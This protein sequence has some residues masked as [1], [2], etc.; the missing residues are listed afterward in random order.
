MDK[1]NRVLIL[2]YN[3]LDLLG[4]DH[5]ICADALALLDML[6]EGFV[7]LS[8]L[9]AWTGEIHQFEDLLHTPV[10]LGRLLPASAVLHCAR[11][12]SLHSDTIL[13]VQTIAAWTLK[14]ERLYDKLA[15]PADEEV[16]CGGHP[17]RL[18]DLH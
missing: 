15:Q 12:A 5:R 17:R 10:H 7:A 11:P 13:A 6:E 9:A 1:G 2:S 4:R 16:N 3:L 14:R 8:F 18:V